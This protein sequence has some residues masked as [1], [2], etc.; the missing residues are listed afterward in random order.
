M[1]VEK[2]C[3]NLYEFMVRKGQRIRIIVAQKVSASIPFLLF[4]DCTLNIN[5]PRL[6]MLMP[7]P[8]MPHQ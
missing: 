6:A 2:L 5:P 8:Y 7:Y 4:G 1:R 3:T